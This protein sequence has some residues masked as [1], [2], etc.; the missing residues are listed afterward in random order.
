MKKIFLM[1][2][3]AGMFAACNTNTEAATETDTTNTDTVEVVDTT[4]TDTTI[5]E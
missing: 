1:L 4:L 2:A 5:A 3:I